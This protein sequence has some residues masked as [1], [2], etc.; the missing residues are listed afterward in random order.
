MASPHWTEVILRTRAKLACVDS[1]VNNLILNSAGIESRE[2]GDAFCFIPIERSTKLVLAW[3][4]GL[5]A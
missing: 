4:L 3:H 1:E 2:I 5:D